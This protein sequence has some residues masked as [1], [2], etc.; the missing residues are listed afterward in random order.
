VCSDFTLRFFR[1]PGSFAAGKRF[2]DNGSREHGKR[3][4][5][6]NFYVL[7]ERERRTI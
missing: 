3:Q 1:R 5:G 7:L 4:T 6:Q 2:P